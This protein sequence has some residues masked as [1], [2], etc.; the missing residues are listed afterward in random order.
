[1]NSHQGRHAAPF[2]I[3]APY[4]MA[5]ALGRN[6]RNIEIGPRLNK[7]K[8]NIKPMGEEKRSSLFQVWR[9]LIGVDVAL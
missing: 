5:R 6:H 2:E 7:I 8:M 9:K 3:F 4:S 1:M